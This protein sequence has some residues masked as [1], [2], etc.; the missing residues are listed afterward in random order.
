MTWKEK[1][2]SNLLLRNTLS[3]LL[4]FPA[5]VANNIFTPYFQYQTG[6]YKQE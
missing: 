4:G 1:L 3:A 2:H 5:A 6:N